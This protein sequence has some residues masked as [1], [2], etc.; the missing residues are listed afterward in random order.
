MY[1]MS[2]SNVRRTICLSLSLIFSVEL[3]H[4]DVEFLVGPAALGGQYATI[5]AAVDA[6]PASNTVRHVIKILPGTYNARVIVP[7]GK[8]YITLRGLGQNPADT[9]ITFNEPADAQPNESTNHATLVVRPRDFIAEN[10]TFRNSYQDETGIKKQA[11]AAYVRGDRAIFNDVRFLGWQD[12]LRSESGRHYFYNSY[13]EGSTDFIYGKGTAYFENMSIY[14]KDD[15]TITAQAREQSTDTN[16]YVFK[17]ATITGDPLNVGTGSESLGRPWAAYSRV[18]FIDTKMSP[19]ISAAGWSQWSGNNNHL[20]AY[21]AE[22]NS[23]DLNGDPLNVSGR[24]SW[25]HQLTA[26]QIAPYSKQN[27]LAGSDGWNPTAVTTPSP[28]AD[29]NNDD[30]VSGED[31]LILQRG[32]GLTGQTDNSNGDADFDGDVD[33]IDQSVWEL[34]YG[35]DFSPVGA[36]M[37][38]P[39][40]ATCVMGCAAMLLACRSLKCCRVRSI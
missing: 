27:W 39:E 13:V 18:I 6:V 4:A 38:V 17:N 23:M 1:L 12:T 32:L 25:S 14:A 22:H 9:L 33:F 20:T 31:F 3:A 19:I 40:P 8:H 28:L 11:L 24:V 10:L 16:G 26:G 37:A 35:E 2:V 7:D 34:Q 29:F 21:Y 5:Q 30:V 36:S 15:S